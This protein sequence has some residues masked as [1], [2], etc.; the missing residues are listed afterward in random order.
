MK[1]Y[2]TIMIK[3][4]IPGV[5]KRILKHKYNDAFDRFSFKLVKEKHSANC[6]EIVFLTDGNTNFRRFLDFKAELNDLVKED[7][8]VIV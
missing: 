5:K 3:K 8:I 4:D 6:F 1:S 2:K 7:Y